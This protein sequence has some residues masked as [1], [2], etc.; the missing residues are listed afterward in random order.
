[1]AKNRVTITKET[2]RSISRSLPG[3]K[4]LVWDDRL[5]GFGAYRRTDGIVVFVYQYRLPMR[6]ARRITIG[7]LGEITPAQAREIA[8][9]HAF[10]KSRGADPIDKR[11]AE[12]R[13]ADASKSL[14]MKTYIANYI[15]RRKIERKPLTLQHER[16]LTRDVAGLMPSKR[17]DR[18]TSGDID[19]FLKEQIGRAHV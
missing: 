4:E 17:I 5:L 3:R 13:E 7:K 1:M 10:N 9:E 6:P 19:A 2:V 11:R 12:A 14:V 18:L 8:Q 15:E 16:I